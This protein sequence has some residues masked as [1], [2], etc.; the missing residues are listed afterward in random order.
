[1]SK[2]KRL[3]FMT[4]MIPPIV[5]SEILASKL[6][7]ETIVSLLNEME[8]KYSSQPKHF[9]QKSVY[10]FWKTCAQCNLP[11][12]TH[13]HTQ[14]LRNQICSKN[15]ANQKASISRIGQ[16][17]A[18]SAKV[19]VQCAVCDKIL[20][21]YPSHISK[22]KMIVC[23]RQCN[24]KLRATE[25]VKHSH[26]ARAHWSQEAEQRWRNRITGETNPAWKG[27]VTYRKRKGLYA[28]QPIKYVRC[29]AEF[30]SMARSDGYVMEH[31]IVVALTIGRPLSRTEVVHHINHNATDNNINN[32][33]LF[34]TN[35]EHKTYEHRKS[36]KPLWC[37]LC[38][39]RT[40]GKSG[41]CECH[42]VHL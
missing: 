6:S 21:R 19:A 31:R 37:G 17:K 40:Q 38:H 10:P 22:S 35:A 30:L 25:L 12:Q 24:G 5:L 41:V 34:A 11:F 33:M 13:N 2:Y 15:C 14:R 32:L 28:N 1:M 4:T 29:P 18:T 39:S 16:K 27:G 23:S 8:A 9:N 3:L 42:Q 26:K 7:A 36:I 20:M